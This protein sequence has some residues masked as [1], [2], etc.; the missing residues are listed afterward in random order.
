MMKTLIGLIACF[1]VLSVSI[2]FGQFESGSCLNA[3]C[4]SFLM[5]QRQGGR[6]TPQQAYESGF[7]QGV[8]VGA[9]DAIGLEQVTDDTRF[10]RLCFPPHLDQKDAT[11][12]VATY[13]QTH[14]ELRHLAAYALVRMAIAQ[15]FPCK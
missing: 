13:L 3:A 2:S 12:I 11:E 8:V 1:H 14:P 15:S 10:V 7:C 5:T 9:L 6:G 4:G